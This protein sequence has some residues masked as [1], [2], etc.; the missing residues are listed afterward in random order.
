MATLKT[1]HKH[2]RSTPL[3]YPRDRYDLAAYK[4]A[5]QVLDMLTAHRKAVPP[6]EY[7][8]IKVLALDGHMDAA[9]Y[10]LERIIWG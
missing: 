3:T 2:G 9:R 1:T 10:D 6:S 4:R 8:R 5:A 7:V